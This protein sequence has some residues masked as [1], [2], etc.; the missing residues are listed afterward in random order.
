MKLF[1]NL[2][3]FKDLASFNGIK[4]VK[5]IDTV[6]KLEIFDVDDNN[7]QLGRGNK[8]ALELLDKHHIP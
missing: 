6:Q 7:E 4:N 5:Q 1:A 8:A 2:T 3:H